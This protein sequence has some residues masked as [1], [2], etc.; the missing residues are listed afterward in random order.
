MNRE[1]GT[2]IRSV[3]KEWSHDQ[4][5]E[6]YADLYM[7]YIDSDSVKHDF[8]NAESEAVKRY[9]VAEGKIKKFLTALEGLGIVS[10]LK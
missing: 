5:L 1:H 6:R 7:A 3:A 8:I 9:K 4:L 2:Y 10:T